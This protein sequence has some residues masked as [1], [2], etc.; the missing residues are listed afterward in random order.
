[1]KIRN[2]VQIFVQK[3]NAVSSMKMVC[4]FADVTVTVQT[5]STTNV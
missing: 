1:M 3:T 5:K 2:A 4:P